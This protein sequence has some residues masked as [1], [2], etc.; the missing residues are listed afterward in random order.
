M[1]QLLNKGFT[2]TWFISVEFVST[3]SLGLCWLVHYEMILSNTVGGDLWKSMLH[4]LW[5]RKVS[6]L[7]RHILKLLNSCVLH[8]ELASLFFILMW[9]FLCLPS[10]WY[11][12]LFDSP[13]IIGCVLK[14]PQQTKVCC[15]ISVPLIIPCLW[16]GTFHSCFK[17]HV[18]A[19][20]IWPSD[21]GC[22]YKST[23]LVCWFFRLSSLC[24][25]ISIVPDGLLHY[26]LLL[27]KP[28][29]S[30]LRFSGTEN[31]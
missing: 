26:I 8:S 27:C 22:R 15:V 9:E 1:P 2:T 10:Q 17:F 7:S 21:S 18:M 20:C 25:R 24:W 29:R 12:L 23:C 13:L 19:Q 11:V 30:N 5:L 14:G 3:Y 6:Y 4:L 16:A 31:W 28:Q